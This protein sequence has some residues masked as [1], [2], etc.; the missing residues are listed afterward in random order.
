MAVHG[1]SGAS[2]YWALYEQVCFN[3]SLTGVRHFLSR[4]RSIWKAVPLAGAKRRTELPLKRAQ[5]GVCQ[6]QKP[7]AGVCQAEN[8]RLK[9]SCLNCSEIKEERKLKDKLC[10]LKEIFS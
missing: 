6:M 10:R 4:D 8:F 3:L 7:G 5:V 1:G 2:F 9:S